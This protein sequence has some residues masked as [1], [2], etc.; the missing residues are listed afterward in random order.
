MLSSANV[1]FAEVDKYAKLE[2]WI[3][4][5]AK[6]KHYVDR[7]EMLNDILNFNP[8]NSLMTY[9]EYY[10]EYKGHLLFVDNTGEIYIAKA[11]DLDSLAGNTVVV[12]NFRDR[13]VKTDN[14]DVD[15]ELKIIPVKFESDYIIAYCTDDKGK[16]L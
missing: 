9:S 13:I 14:S 11:P 16:I 2:P 12:H 1:G 10:N 4:E 7:V 3:L 15:I 6:Q 5:N 8:E